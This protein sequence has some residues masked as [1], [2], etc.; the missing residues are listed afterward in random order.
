MNPEEVFNSVILFYG[1]SQYWENTA[2]VI[3]IVSKISLWYLGTS[4]SDS[5]TSEHLYLGD[6]IQVISKPMANLWESANDA[7]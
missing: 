1:F 4:F 3:R 5:F 2:R 6:K 7:A